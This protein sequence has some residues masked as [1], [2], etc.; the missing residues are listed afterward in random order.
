MAIENDD[1]SV[2]DKAHALASLIPVFFQKGTLNKHDITR[3]GTLQDQVFMQAFTHD[4]PLH[5]LTRPTYDSLI[6]TDPF[7]PLLHLNIR[8]FPTPCSF[9]KTGWLEHALL[10]LENWSPGFALN[11]QYGLQALVDDKTAIVEGMRG[12]KVYYATLI[13]LRSHLFDKGLP[14]NGRLTVPLFG[15]TDLEC[16]DYW[17]KIVSLTQEAMQSCMTLRHYA[18]HQRVILQEES[19]LIPMP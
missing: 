7:E 18:F 8:A 4:K 3:W 11:A 1:I 14:E 15:L 10:D 19:P 6:E 17:H 9:V 2:F 5:D 16:Y 12:W 13:F